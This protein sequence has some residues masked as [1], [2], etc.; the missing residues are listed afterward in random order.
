M[1]KLEFEIVD[2]SLFM[3]DMSEIDNSGQWCIVAPDSP[4]GLNES[5]MYDCSI[6]H[7]SN[8]H[9]QYPDKHLG[10]FETLRKA[11]EYLTFLWINSMT[12]D[13]LNAVKYIAAPNKHEF[14]QP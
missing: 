12:Y 2:A 8:N 9:K 7:C 1:E 14:V 5:E 3:A 6:R 4:Y 11:K 10:S 13:N